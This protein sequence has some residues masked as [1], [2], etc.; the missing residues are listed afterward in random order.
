[1]AERNPDFE[2]SNRSFRRNLDLV[3]TF[4]H[5]TGGMLSVAAL[6]IILTGC[7]GD[8]GTEARYTAE[9]TVIQPGKPG[10]PATTIAPGETGTRPATPAANAADVRFLQ[11][12]IGH[13]AQALQ[14]ADLA[15]G[16]ARDAR[17]ISLADR[18]RAG[19]AAE[20]NA[21]RSWLT[22]HGKPAPSGSP[23][24]DH[25]HAGGAAAMPGMV[26]QAQLDA[27][28]RASGT[29]FD[30][31]FLDVMITHHDGAVRMSRDVAKAGTDPTVQEIAA[32]T[33]VTQAAEIARMQDVRAT[34]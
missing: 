6:A 11:L 30:Q 21:L 33:A 34:L 19:Q 17:V 31:T 27:L 14:V 15:P 13:H 23:G 12:M 2:G 16:R 22:S 29:Q 24:A 26:T 4:G 20:I 7:S 8:D 10:E 18:I 1:M 5:L 3:H 32:E 25:G 28:T 9:A